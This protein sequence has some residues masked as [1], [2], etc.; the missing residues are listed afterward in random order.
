MPK[1]YR[2]TALLLITDPKI[3]GNGGVRLPSIETYV[4]IIKSQT[5]AKEVLKKF[6]LDKPPHNLTFEDLIDGMISATPI[7]GTNLIRIEVEYTDPE[8]ARDI[9]NM[10]AVSAVELN[11]ALNEDE[12]VK[13]RD[14]LKTQLDE[15]SQA[16]A[17][18][19]Q[20]LLAFKETAG[21][22]KL[23]KDIEILLEEKRR[24]EIGIG[25]GEKERADPGLLGI[26]RA[27]EEKNAV[28]EVLARR[29]ENEKKILELSRSITDD[30]MMQEI[31]KET[32]NLPI[33]ALLGIQVK[34]EQVNPLHQ[35]LEPILVE[36]RSNLE[37]LKAKK[38]ILVADLGGV[39]KQL[40]DLQK[41]LAQKEMKLENL[42]RT[43]ELNK[44]IYKSLKQR[45]DEARIQVASKTQEL[46]LVD[47]AIIPGNPIKP[48]KKMNVLTTGAVALLGLIIL[49]FLLEYISGYYKVK[50]S[51]QANL[52]SSLP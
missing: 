31:I 51:L 39:E 38:A 50:P 10:V 28:V 32:S 12:A 17:K 2:A 14:F 41:E 43:Y 13:S 27:I 29:L 35:A 22:A 4:G 52:D 18:A 16:L 33:S 19:E 34:N 40:A 11:K 49:A 25:E 1:V 46:K 20:E 26:D 6:S 5:V 9:A 23:R 7:K 3:S 37:G 30:A 45:F 42:T 8:K 15:A 24:I 47:S 48:N 36:A 21:I 44:E